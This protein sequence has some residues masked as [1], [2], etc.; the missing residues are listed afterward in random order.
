LD[1]LLAFRV[2]SRFDVTTEAADGLPNDGFSEEVEGF[3]SFLTKERRVSKNTSIA[4]LR[5]LTQLGTFLRERLKRD[6]VPADATRLLVRAHLAA[7][8]ESC[9]TTSLSRKL[10]A[11]RSF[12][13]YLERLGRCSN[14]PL[15]QI[16]SPK[17]RRKLPRFLEPEAAQQVMDAPY[18]VNSPE[19]IRDR[20][21]LEL[22]YGSGL[23]VSELVGLD[24]VAI[25]FGRAQLRVTGKGNKERIVP[26]GHKAEEALKAYLPVRDDYFVCA[27]RKEVRIDSK[28][29]LLLG[30]GG[31][32]LSA[33]WIQR[34][35]QRYGN[36]GAS[37]PDLHPH[38]LRHSC[39]THMLE[40]GADLRIIQEMLGH[41]S[42]STTQRYTH[43]SMNE[44]TRIYDS[45]HPLARTTG[46]AET[47]TKR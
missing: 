45:A 34:L 44:L 21:I 40:G 33:R 35:C 24:V 9:T 43:L 18:S 17:V 15:G 7:L 22:L 27:D 4:Y 13:R 37:R 12:Y 16:A 14:S 3:I 2:D 39:A 26:L 23:R 42:L 32:R 19:G 8:T 25:D 11:L 20:V 41:S 5:D 29:A 1:H 10:S 46:L 36:L 31:R 38:A 47:R 30:R 6:V 28:G